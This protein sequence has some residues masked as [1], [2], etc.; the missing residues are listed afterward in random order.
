MPTCGARREARR[1]NRSAA[2]FQAAAALLSVLANLHRAIAKID[3]TTTP[4]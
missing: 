3:R 4:G 2:I 1:R